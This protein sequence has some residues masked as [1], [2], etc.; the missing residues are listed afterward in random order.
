V[1]AL[2]ELKRTPEKLKEGD[3]NHRLVKHSALPLFYDRAREKGV[4]VRDLA[5]K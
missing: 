3:E 5:K 1:I 4:E 2:L